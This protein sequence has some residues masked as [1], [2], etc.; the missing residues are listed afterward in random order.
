MRKLLGLLLCVGICA[1]LGFGSL[2]CT[3]KPADKKADKAVGAPKKTDA[4]KKMMDKKIEDKKTEDAKIPEDKKTED[5][6]TEDKKTEDKKTEDKKTEDKKTADKKTEDKKT[7]DKK[8]DDKK[9]DKKTD[10]K[11]ALLNNGRERYLAQA[12]LQPSR[13][14]LASV[15]EVRFLAILPRNNRFLG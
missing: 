13:D 5:K 6:K 3:K 2:G 14:A 1:V 10:D 7:E 15:R 8:T 4:D 9:A 12:M 11:K